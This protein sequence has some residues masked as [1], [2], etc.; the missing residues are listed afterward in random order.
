MQNINLHCL[1]PAVFDKF[2]VA[3][4]NVDG[5][6]LNDAGCL[7]HTLQLVIHDGLF[8]LPSVE[9]LIAKCRRVATFANHS[10]NFYTEFYNQQDIYNIKNKPSLKQD[11]E[12]R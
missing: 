6:I 8:S 1:N 7:N 3:A 12:T 2:Q 4:F 5:S 10:T 11:V 9:T